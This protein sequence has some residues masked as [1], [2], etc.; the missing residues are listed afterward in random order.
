MLFTLAST[1][2]DMRNLATEDFQVPTTSPVGSLAAEHTCM[3]KRQFC[4]TRSRAA[5]RLNW[6]A[7]QYPSCMGFAL[8]CFV[9]RRMGIDDLHWMLH[10]WRTRL[11]SAHRCG[12]SKNVV[13][14]PSAWLLYG[15]FSCPRSSGFFLVARRELR[16]RALML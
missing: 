14:L 6:L 4:A 1:L 12:Y 15:P 7:M 2:P 3:R 11:G 16:G 5:R 8:E 10:T 9:C 13:A